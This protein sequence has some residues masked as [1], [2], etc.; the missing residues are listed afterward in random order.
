M[1]AYITGFADLIYGRDA[2]AAASTE[3]TPDL[4]AG[5]GGYERAS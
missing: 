4:A 2:H 5:G 1:I 3:L